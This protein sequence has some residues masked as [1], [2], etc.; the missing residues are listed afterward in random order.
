MIRIENLSH[1]HDGVPALKD[2]SF[3]LDP[4]QKVTL[5]GANGSGK[6]TL[7]KAINGLIEPRVG[8]VLLWGRDVAEAEKDKEF[9]R[10]LRSRT[11]LLFQNPEAMLFNPTV[12]EEIAF[13]PL[14]FG[15]DNVDDRVAHWSGELQITDLLD[16]SPHALSNGEKQRVC[17]A[18]LLAVE[19]DLLLLDEPTASLD[20]RSTGWL[21]DFL[22]NLPTTVITSTHNLSLATELGERCLLLGEDHTLL[23][24]GDVLALRDDLDLLRQANLVHIHDHQHR[25]GDVTHRHY[26]SHDWD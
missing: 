11:G 1:D 16:R 21:V 14:H 10:E 9:R 23:Y 15:L 8:R 20:P 3:A 6:S 17:L 22:Q 5:L 26:H 18:L 4:G 7:L 25:K 24:D 2:I 13:G 12:R 19:P